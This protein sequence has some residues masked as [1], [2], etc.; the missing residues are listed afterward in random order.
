MW[1]VGESTTFSVARSA[2]GSWNESSAG[3]HVSDGGEYGVGGEYVGE[4]WHGP[5]DHEQPFP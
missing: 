1:R 3:R 2:G 4:H 5:E